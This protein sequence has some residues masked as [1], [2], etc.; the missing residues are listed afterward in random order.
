MAKGPADRV[1]RAIES[2]RPF[3]SSVCLVVA[4]GDPL[5]GLALPIPGR[6]VTQQ[7]LGYAATRTATL[8][9]AEADP[10]VEWVLML[11]A[12]GRVRGRM[13]DLDPVADSYEIAIECNFPD[14]CWRWMRAGHLMRARR[15]LHWTGA[16]HE[17][18][19]GAANVRTWHGLIYEGVASGARDYAGDVA[20]LEDRDPR[21]TRAAFYYAQSLKD[22]GRYEEALVAFLRRAR[23]RGFSEEVFW[24][25]LWAGK[26]AL[27]LGKT[28]LSCVFLHEAS[29]HSPERAEPYAYQSEIYRRQGDHVRARELAALA[30]SK[31]YPTS[32]RLFVDVGCY[33]DAPI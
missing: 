24:A 25:W 26:L 23:M 14:G 18:L 6:I 8:R 27:C 9:H 2:A 13:P 22:S 16:I 5:E 21:D 11:D 33:P 1:L 17:T 28:A 15:G 7:W 19:A 3:V 12:N 29:R 10:A 31:P 20:I 30:A 4:P 32:A